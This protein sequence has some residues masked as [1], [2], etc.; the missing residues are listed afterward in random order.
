MDRIAFIIG[1]V[2]LYW[3]SIV[4]TL[5]V[6][7][8]ICL[9]LAFY[10][11]RGGSGAAA[12]VT[13]PMAMVLS[14]VTSRLL[15]WY[16]RPDS[17][18][19]FAAAMTDYTSGGYALLGVFIGCALTAALVRLIQLDKSLPDMLDAMSL[20]GCAGIAVGRLACFFSAADRG[21]LLEN[22]RELPW[23]YPVTNVVTGAPEYRLA[24]FVFQAAAAGLIFLL[25]LAFRSVGKARKGDV[26]LLFLL[27]Y[28]MSQAILDSTRYDSL[29]MRSNGFISVVQLTGAIAMVS[30][31]VVFGV[32]MVR[33]RGFRVWYLAIWL[34][35]LACMGGGG[36]MEYYVQ[37]HG[38]L[39]LFCYSIMTAC[40]SAIV[41]LALVTYSLGNHK[42]P[43]SKPSKA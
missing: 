30:M 6:A 42:R 21:L 22:F 7:A 38:D 23:A 17:Y 5:A 10:L 43:K 31:C 16:F 2:F 37:R 29:F 20:G 25:L 1:D 33:A 12:A 14:I 27:F 35:M 18:S 41:S 32:R 28:G 36:Y 4:L 11:S 3:N 15:H 34:A 9:F 26:T 40:F 19:G 39:P 13:V 8:A 24:T